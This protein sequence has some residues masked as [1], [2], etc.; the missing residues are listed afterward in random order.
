MFELKDII[1]EGHPTLR[2]K[3]Q[4]V[5]FPLSSDNAK[6]AQN[7]H[8][9]VK[10]SQDV[11]ML[12]RYDLRPGIGIAAPQVNESKRM[13]ALHLPDDESKLSLVVINPKIISHSVEKTYITVGEGCLSVDRVIEGYVPRYARI[14]AKGFY[15]DGSEFKLRLK[16]LSAIAFQ[17]ELDHLNGV[18]FYD[19]INKENPFEEIP[20]SVPFEKENKVE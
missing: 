10:N 6:L 3:A 8:D 16:G 18:M 7:L 19:R 12:E 4:E 1:R 20:N 15:K 11:E 2:Q 5:K 13:F 9:Y 14:T 17:H